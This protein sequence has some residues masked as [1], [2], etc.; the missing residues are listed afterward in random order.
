MS[1]L[2]MSPISVE[3]SPQGADFTGAGRFCDHMICRWTRDESFLIEHYQD[4][5]S[6][7]SHVSSGAEY[8]KRYHLLS[9]HFLAVNSHVSDMYSLAWDV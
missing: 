3:T 5:Q 2:P 9:L 8:C 4:W 7:L 1:L 6:P